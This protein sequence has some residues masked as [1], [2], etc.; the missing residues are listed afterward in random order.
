MGGDKQCWTCVYGMNRTGEVSCNNGTVIKLRKRSKPDPYDC[1][2]YEELSDDYV[3]DVDKVY[4]EW[5]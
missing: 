1:E 3:A 2:F 5:N 4:R